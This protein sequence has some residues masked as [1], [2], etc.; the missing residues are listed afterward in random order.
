MIKRVTINKII[1]G[2]QSKYELHALVLANVIIVIF[3]H[4]YPYCIRTINKTSLPV[5]YLIK[6]ENRSY[7]SS[8]S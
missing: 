1:Y 5:S 2:Y 8:Q 7:H 3:I 4:K 6:E